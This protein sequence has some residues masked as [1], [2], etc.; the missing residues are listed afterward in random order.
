MFENEFAVKYK[1]IV[2]SAQLENRQKN[3]GVYFESHHIVP[4]FMFKNRKRR[5]P[6]GHLDG[7]PDDPTNLVLLTFKEHLLCHFYLFEMCKNTNY[8]YSAGSA[9]QF[10]F[11]KAIGQHA[12]QQQLSK[13]DEEMLEEW[14]FL[15]E[16]GIASI[17]AARK[18]KMPAV[19]AITREKVGSVP[20]DHPKVLSGEW[21]H[22]TK[23]KKQSAEALKN[24]KNMK[25]CYNSN[26]KEFTEDRKLRVFKC[27]SRSVLNNHL[28]VGNF[29]KELKKEFTEFKKI[30]HQWI[31]NNFGSY[32]NLINQFNFQT[33][34]AVQYD[35]YFFRGKNAKN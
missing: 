9:L 27:V 30:S 25:G 21:V 14:S 2:T 20:T 26:F 6:K 5:G 17:R 33:N 12:R 4:D 11:T 34:S 23:G 16:I 24:K 19:D 13:I 29:T 15:R 1:E 28:H 3:C 31:L 10:F 22:H 8:E 35:P 7:N 18:G 32:S